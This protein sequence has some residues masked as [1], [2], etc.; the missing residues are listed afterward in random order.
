MGLRAERETSV[1]CLRTHPDWGLNLQPFSDWA[2]L[3]SGLVYYY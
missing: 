3:Q 1:R 2:M